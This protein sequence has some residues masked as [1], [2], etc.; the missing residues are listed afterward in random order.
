M[1]RVVRRQ[2]L[3]RLN[4]DATRIAARFGLRYRTVAAERAGVRRRYGSCHDDGTIRIRLEHAR[5]GAPLRYSSLMDTLCHELAHLRYWNHNAR[6]RAYHRKLLDYAR[7]RGLYQ[8]TPRA[9]ARRVPAAAREAATARVTAAKRGVTA[10]AAREAAAKRGVAVTARETTTARVTAA[11]REAAPTTRTT[12]TART[13]TAARE[14]ASARETTTATRAQ[15]EQLALFSGARG[16]LTRPARTAKAAHARR[17][18]AAVTM[19]SATTPSAARARRS[20][21]TT[22]GGTVARGR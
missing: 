2:L 7:A 8:P 18:G 13:A 4:R 20:A 19:R 16:P 1:E 6:F 5:T 10:A 22:A 3:A 9:S 15:P 14:A 21:L 12:A 17:H 11:E